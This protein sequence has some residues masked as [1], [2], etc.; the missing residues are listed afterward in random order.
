MKQL[1]PPILLQDDCVFILQS[2]SRRGKWNVKVN[3]HAIFLEKMDSFMYNLAQR[4]K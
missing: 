1:Y 3:S 2:K 4:E